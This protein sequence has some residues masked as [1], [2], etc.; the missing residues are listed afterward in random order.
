MARPNIVWIFPD[1][2]RHDAFGFQGN[3]VVQT[4][5]I[6]ALAERG[7]V[8][9]A[10]HCESPV[11][12]PSRASLLTMS[13]PSEHGLLDL[14]HLPQWRGAA[15]PKPSEPNVLHQL[16]AAGYRTAVVGK[17]HFP[18]DEDG[19]LQGYGFDLVLEEFDKYEGRTKDTPYTRYLKELGM[20][21]AW[22]LYLRSLRHFTVLSGTV[23]PNPYYDAVRGRAGPDPIV[24]LQHQLDTFIGRQAADLI[25]G[26]D[27]DEPFFLW[28]APIGPHSPWD[29]PAEIADRYRE[30][31]IPLPLLGF[32]GFP[33]GRWGDYNRW[34]Y[35]HL[36]CEELTEDLLRRI[37]KYYYGNC[38]IVD[39]AVGEV[40][41]ALR[42]SGRAQDTWIFLS[43]DHG[44][45]LGDHGLLTKRVFYRSSV[46]VPQLIVPP[47]GRDLGIRVDGLT[48]GFDLLATMLD[49]AGAVPPRGASP[50]RSLL[51]ALDGGQ[52]GRDVV[53]SEIAGFLMVATEQHKLVIHK[54]SREVGALYDLIADPDE[55][56][57][58]VAME[59]AGPTL[60]SLL[61]LANNYLAER[62]EQ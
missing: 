18:R 6:D 28:V 45:L 35:Q 3:R 43:S 33:P 27:R 54:A 61:R 57:N 49:L 15:F 11:C 19:G 32:D 20:F 62:V 10:A 1:A 34:N 40:V 48:Q 9:N 44:E 25:R 26:Y 2:W 30:E 38:T 56:R 16:R 58:L 21:E 29:A 46:L 41:R 36:R 59:G 52:V 13:Y 17:T 51:T 12:Q 60:V 37:G 31:D 5:N 39:N 55:R 50:A 53:Y 22:S 7:A 8:F 4:P 24:P 42:T 14:E 47:A 23:Q